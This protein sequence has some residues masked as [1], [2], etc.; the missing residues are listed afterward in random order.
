MRF[1]AFFL[2]YLFSF[3]GLGAE[4]SEKGSLIVTYQTGPKAERL[5]RIRFWLKQGDREAHIYPKRNGYLEDPS[6]LCRMVVIENL[7]PGTYTLVFAIPNS[8]G[9]FEEVKPRQVVVT[10][11]N[12]TKVDQMIKP[13]H[14]DHEFVAENS[15]SK[16]SDQL[17]KT[18]PVLGGKTIIGDPFQEGH[19]NELPSKIVDISPFRIGIYEVTNAQYAQWLTEAFRKKTVLLKEG[20]I[21][22]QQNRLLFKTQEATPHSQIYSTVNGGLTYFLPLIGKGDFPVV[23]VSWYGAKAYCQDN[24]CRLPTETEWER[25][26][27][28]AATSSD[29]PPKKYRY[30]FGKDSIDKSW[31]NYKDTN[32]SIAEFSLLTT[33]VGFYNGINT[34][35]DGTKTQLAT[36]PFGAFDMSGNVWEWVEDWYDE[37]YSKNMPQKDPKGPSRGTQKVAKGGCYDSLA[38]GVRVSERLAL[39]PDHLDPYTGFRIAKSIND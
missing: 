34:L 3:K 27:G 19:Q 9:F 37:N 24:H 13:R 18:V 38:A 1:L 25:A 2:L 5:S 12:V 36:S 14:V 16:F 35:E 30:G 29:Q 39:S 10:A 17:Q 32:K 11:G 4:D 20:Q 28:M 6:R 31:A 8:D 26:A 7:H 21:Y 33:K 22:D 15:P 23:S